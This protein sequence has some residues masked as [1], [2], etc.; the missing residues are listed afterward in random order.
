MVPIF[1]ASFYDTYQNSRDI[2]MLIEALV[3]YVEGQNFEAY[4]RSQVHSCL[5]YTPPMHYSDWRPD[6]N[7]GDK[8]GE[9]CN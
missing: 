1:I 8:D 5:L 4:F 6:G 2:S 3:R 9:K 7:T